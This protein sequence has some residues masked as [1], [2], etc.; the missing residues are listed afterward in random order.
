MA[1]PFLH[2]I[3]YIGFLTP[4]GMAMTQ[5]TAKIQKNKSH[6]TALLQPKAQPQ[7]DKKEINR[8]S[9]QYHSMLTI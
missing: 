2:F 6:Q 3:F 8:K 4:V 7:R 9:C 1:S 5:K